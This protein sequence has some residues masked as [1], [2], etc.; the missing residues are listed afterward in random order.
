M[1]PR[2]LLPLA[3]CLAAGCWPFRSGGLEPFDPAGRKLAL[4]MPFE[5]AAADKSIDGL[6]RLIADKLTSALFDTK[7]VRVIDPRRLETTLAEM[8]LPP[9]T[10]LDAAQ[11]AAVCKQLDVEEAVYGKVVTVLKQ[12]R[13]GKRHTTDTLTV[14]IEAQLVAASTTE[15]IA[16]ARATGTATTTYDPD[17]AP[18]QEALVNQALTDAAGQAAVLLVKELQ[19]PA[20]A[21]AFSNPSYSSPSSSDRQ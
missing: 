5:V 11:I 19:A 8:K 14:T 15:V 7:R 2:Y 12:R 20:A 13:P 21:A 18:P 1:R 10:I 4:V 3:A 17:H 6:S 9:D 16:R